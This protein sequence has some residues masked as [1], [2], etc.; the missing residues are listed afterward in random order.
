LL[1]GVLVASGCVK[2]RSTLA[3]AGPAART[4]ADLGWPLLIGFTGV[5]AIMWGLLVWVASR[6][7]GTF[8][9]H[10]P[11]HAKGGIGWVVIGGFVVPGIAFTA[12][13]VA[14]LGAM[15]AFPLD[16]AR[17]SHP[18]IRVVGRQWWWEVEYLIGDLPQH[19][20]TANEIHVPTDR[21]IEIELDSADVIHSFWVPRLHGK[22]DLVPGYPNHI[23]IRAPIAGTYVG[24][25]AEFCGLEHARMRM[26]VVAEPPE[27]FQRWLEQQ[28]RPAAIAA[29]GND[30]AAARG[31]AV[32]EGA[33]CPVC[34]SI[35][36]TRAAAS[37][38]P[39]LTH[40]GS[41]TTLAAG[42]LPKDL[43]TLHAWIMNAP[44]LKPGVRMPAL[45]QL[46]GPDL[47]DLV[48]YLEALR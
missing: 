5:S 22:V 36:G 21:A 37:V 23:R 43:A 6:R 35:A 19:F 32:F 9:G 28:R 12:A 46:P 25:C 39:D 7:T 34:H 33:A 45:T 14:T 38:G 17:P 48:S 29:L 20:K 30:P 44:A 13:Y 41:R 2:A 3:P 31:A 1:A 40:I 8:A 24:S 16:H 11:V 26:V 10:A 15:S 27:M 18:Q 4:L 47:H 42:S